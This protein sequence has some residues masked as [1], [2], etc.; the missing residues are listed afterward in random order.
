MIGV[1]RPEWKLLIFSYS[2]LPRVNFALKPLLGWINWVKN[3]TN[4]M[5][6]V[7]NREFGFSPQNFPIN[8]EYI[9]AP[10]RTSTYS[11]LH[12]KHD[13]LQNIHTYNNLLF[14]I[15]HV[16]SVWKINSDDFARRSSDSPNTFNMRGRYLRVIR[17]VNFSNIFELV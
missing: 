17:W 9:V 1:E 15:G 12:L 11:L 10:S 6:S 8:F 14:V 13:L 3:F 4:I 7:V 2:F 16:K 5:L